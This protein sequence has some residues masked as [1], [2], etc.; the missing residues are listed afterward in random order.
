MAKSIHS[1]ILSDEDVGVVVSPHF[2]VRNLLASVRVYMDDLIS[3]L[4]RIENLDGDTS[5]LLRY[6]LEDSSA[7][8]VD[9]R[10]APRMCE[11]TQ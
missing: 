3:H 8:I 4:G 10:L 5:S 6:Y 9:G 11:R 2:L 1:G 7:T